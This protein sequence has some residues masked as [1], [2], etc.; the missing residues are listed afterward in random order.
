MDSLHIMAIG[1]VIAGHNFFSTLLLNLSIPELFLFD[2]DL[3]V[4]SNSFSV[5]GIKYELLQQYGIFFKIF[6]LV[7][8][9]VPTFDW[10]NSIQ[11]NCC[12]SMP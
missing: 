10:H 5:V 11:F 2:N 8:C 1:F 6:S 12:F 7:S 4:A 3:M 9:D